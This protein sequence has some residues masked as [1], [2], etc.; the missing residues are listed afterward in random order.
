MTSQPN[1]ARLMGEP[2]FDEVFRRLKNGEH[3]AL[4]GPRNG[5]KSIVLEELSRKA[6]QLS[7]ANRPQV[8]RIVCDKHSSQGE[9]HFLKALAGKLG[10]PKQTSTRGGERFSA[11][12]VELV[13]EAARRH[14]CPIWLFAQDVLALP[15]SI[16]RELLEGFQML[17]G[18]TMMNRIAVVATGSADFIPLTYGD[19]SPYRHARKYL[20]S[21]MDKDCAANFYYARRQRQQW[22]DL[23]EEK[24]AAGSD[25]LAN[26]IDVEGFDYLYD[27][28]AG[29][30][31]F[32]QEI[33]VSPVRHGRDDEPPHLKDKWTRK[34]VES[35]VSNYASTFMPN[36]FFVRMVL[37]EAENDRDNFDLLCQT[38]DEGD[39]VI[40][41]EGTSPHVLE[42]NGLIRRDPLNKAAIACPLLREFLKEY[43]SRRH[44]AD[45]LATQH[46]WAQAWK[47]YS[48]LPKGMRDRPVSGDPRF[49][50]RHLI[51]DWQDSFMDRAHEGIS[52]VCDHFF[53]GA[54][55]LLGFDAA[56]LFD[57]SKETSR[58]LHRG[59]NNMEAIQEYR[60]ARDAEPIHSDENSRLYLDLP[61]RLRVWSERLR[62][63]RPEAKAQPALSLGRIGFGRE[64]DGAEQE[65]LWRI[66]QRFWNAYNTAE[67]I[68]HKQGLGELREKHLR[69]IQHL[70]AML[71][72]EL[73]DFGKVVQGAAD[74]L[75]DIAGYYRILICLVD[76]KREYIQAVASRCHEPQ[77]DFKFETN[78]PIPKDPTDLDVEKLDIQPWVVVKGQ[79]CV[80][81]DA[82]S[83]LQRD[84]T[85][86]WREV[87]K[88]GMKAITVVPMKAGD[89]V[90][91]TLHFERSN[92]EVP[93]QTEQELFQ[94]LAGQIASIFQQAQR[95]TLLQASLSGLPDAVRIIDPQQR[96]LFLNDTAAAAPE[97]SRR[98]AGWQ[99]HPFP[100]ECPRGQF[101][102][103][104]ESQ[105]L[106]KK[107][108]ESGQPV[109]YYTF[110]KGHHGND[111][112]RHWH[113]APIDDFRAT[114]TEV[115]EANARIGYVERVNDHTEFY[116]LYSSLQE[117]LTVKGVRERAQS[118]LRFFE[119]RGHI[120]GRIY[121]KKKDETG[122]EYLESFEEFGMKEKRHMRAFCRGEMR[123]DRYHENPQ[124]WY[125]IDQLQ[126]PVLYE[127]KADQKVYLDEAPR[128]QGL[129]KFWTRELYY[130]DILEREPS[131]P[132]IEA[133]LFV[134]KHA[135]GKISFG[136]P[137]DV[138]QQ[139]ELLRSAVLGAALALADATLFDEKE[140][141]IEAQTRHLE[142]IRELG[143]ALSS[144]VN[145]DESLR[146]MLETA[147]TSIGATMGSI[148]MYDPRFKKLVY[149]AAWG[150]A[151][152]WTRERI[153][154]EFPLDDTSTGAWVYSH[155][156]P[157][158]NADLSHFKQRRSLLPGV[159]SNC[160]VPILEHGVVEGVLT[161]YS[162]EPCTFS[163]EDSALLG[164]ISSL[165]GALVSQGEA[166]RQESLRSRLARLF[167]SHDKWN[168][169]IQE[170]VK[171][172]AGD[173][174]ET[175]V[176]LFLQHDSKENEFVLTATT[177]KDLRPMIGKA[178]YRAGEGGTGWVIKHREPLRVRGRL[179][180][181]GKLKTDI[182]NDLRF[183]NK[184]KEYRETVPVDVDYLA[185]PLLDA[186]RCVG[187]LRWVTR[188][189]ASRPDKLFTHGDE[190]ILQIAAC[191]IVDALQRR[192]I[193]ASRERHAAETVH[194]LAGPLHLV[195]AWLKDLQALPDLTEEDRR[196]YLQNAEEGIALG[197]QRINR[198]EV[199]EQIRSGYLQAEVTQRSLRPLLE[200]MKANFNPRLAVEGTALRIVCPKRLAV[201]ADP[202]WLREVLDNL[203]DN[204]L[205]F[206]KDSV[207]ILCRES[208]SG[209]V[210]IRVM[211][212]GRGLSSK[213][214]KLCFEPRF[215]TVAKRRGGEGMGLGLSVA[216]ELCETMDG[217]LTAENRKPPAQGAVFTLTLQGGKA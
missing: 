206:T 168:D 188:I 102:P 150:A 158:I 118:I 209:H 120:S 128:T 131:D 157:Q 215:T 203:V 88:I 79:K 133:P 9:L 54:R 141:L 125:V 194:Q 124:P 63:P 83:E 205:I 170:V 67:E 171:T 142:V 169:D 65:A 61:G 107:V 49:R 16:A 126:E 95:L 55:Y 12:V 173:V 72:E 122:K 44:R 191:H 22:Q 82:S 40:P 210:R 41:I 112:V 176:S 92:H 116:N 2:F 181:P 148:R 187:V 177:S 66:L 81:P 130:E 140:R 31:H 84:P 64:I 34:T 35:C 33:V 32:L 14:T 184:W 146:A 113:M 182:A 167:R 37:R 135:I 204:A 15:T 38:L 17:H 100:C 52:T 42:V 93:S 29:M 193:A 200:K 47:A 197:L 198:V 212:N 87:R 183:V 121:L 11:K 151:E 160:A 134:G 3:I 207:E 114:L 60:P 73:F 138:A 156:E 53:L 201:Q 199:W 185:V 147:V 80:V 159:K 144:G 214:L 208:R 180:N 50:L 216:K 103:D 162:N 90:I 28:T 48:R 139:W 104:A 217:T 97:R 69:V 8:V 106:S 96:V 76:G 57:R 175:H 101:T 108:E 68:E 154:M 30:P 132:W 152:V 195:S 62:E 196:E 179:N 7:A 163:R 56:S 1:H 26:F 94:I 39:G 211:D 89:E 117:W 27:R 174:G 46:R 98:R 192:N 13:E 86:H 155:G 137:K 18:D 85:T 123:Y 164:T 161:V 149:R 59:W 19:N 20:V 136:V 165:I 51:T 4:L 36:D 129:R 115:F 119:Q 74:A 75:V 172:V 70:N 23:K 178:G 43:L 25:R 143:T 105:C 45:A 127:V 153:R 99:K 24:V 71:V 109:L 111:L 77:K 202:R 6:G 186:S 213:A 58:L 10:L 166:F 145:V 5:G 78:Y 21:G 110:T 189:E 190:V 91:G